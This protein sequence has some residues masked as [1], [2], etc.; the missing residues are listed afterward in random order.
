MKF[1]QKKGVM[2]FV[3]NGKLHPHYKGPYQIM[4]RIGS[5]AYE[6]DLLANLTLFYP[7]YHV[8]I[9]K[10]FVRYYS[11]VFL[12][13]EIGLTNSFSYAEDIGSTSLKIEN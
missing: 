4:R 6:L 3:K 12:V 13:K 11:N 7:I 5:I 1:S 10:K 8:S 2:R 9:L